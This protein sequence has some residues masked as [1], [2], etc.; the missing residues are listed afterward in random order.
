MDLPASPIGF[1]KVDV[2]KCT[3][4]TK[5]GKPC[6]APR[7]KGTLFCINH[8]SMVAAFPAPPEV[9]QE[10]IPAVELSDADVRALQAKQ[11]KH[12]R[13]GMAS[14]RELCEVDFK[15][16]TKPLFDGLDANL[17]MFDPILGRHVETNI[18]DRKLRMEASKSLLDRVWGK[19]T[20]RQEVTGA[21]GGPITVASI[22]VELAARANQHELL[23][24][25]GELEG[26]YASMPGEEPLEVGPGE[27]V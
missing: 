3:T 19:P 17:V 8:K 1:I 6:L 11:G 14:L 2:P 24:A 21:E 26:Y 15:R 27:E 12:R 25:A 5:K 22:V 13:N 18:P 23:E 7:V 4:T 20:V 16:I 10:I 9:A